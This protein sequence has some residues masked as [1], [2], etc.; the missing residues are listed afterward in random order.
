MTSNAAADIPCRGRVMV[1]LLSNG[2]G[3]PISGAPASEM[4]GVKRENA[5]G[6]D[7]GSSL[8][9]TS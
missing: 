7:V 1:I 3:E 4:G 9:V 6:G 2:T 8:V 5:F